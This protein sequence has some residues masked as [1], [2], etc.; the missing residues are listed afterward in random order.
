MPSK[1]A[2]LRRRKENRKRRDNARRRE[3]LRQADQARREA[4][5]DDRTNQTVDVESS[6]NTWMD[7]I[8][9]ILR[10]ANASRSKDGLDNVHEAAMK[11]EAMKPDQDKNS[12]SGPGRGVKTAMVIAVLAMMA[13]L[14]IPNFL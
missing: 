6:K 1:N 3:E 9:R 8:G 12:K 2:R 13:L 5:T 14:V 4:M 10:P 11:A 7:G